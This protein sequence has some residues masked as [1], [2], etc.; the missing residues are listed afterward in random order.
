MGKAAKQPSF[1]IRVAKAGD[2]ETIRALVAEMRAVAK[3]ARSSGDQTT[4]RAAIGRQM[5]AERRG[6]AL[7]LSGVK[8]ATETGM[9]PG[10]VQR[11]RRLARLSNEIFEAA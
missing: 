6:G 9:G 3:R 8:P 1:E 5:V 2:I 10:T 7:L 4:L 11:W